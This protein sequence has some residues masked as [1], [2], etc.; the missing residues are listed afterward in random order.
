MIG[1]KPFSARHRYAG[2]KEITIREDAP[3]GLR[4]LVLDAARELGW[5]P[6]SLRSLVCRMLR[7][8]PDRGNWSEYPNIWDEVTYLIGRCEWFRVYD[9]IEA[10]YVAL[11]EHDELRGEDKAT[12][13]AEEINRA[14]IE[15]GIGWKLAD[16]QIVTRG[17]EAF[18]A[19]VAEAH[20]SLV[21]SARP[22]AASHIKDAL[23]CMSRR[24]K[25]NASGAVFHAMGS[26]ECIARDIV[27][28]PKATLGEILKRYP[29]LIPK[30]LDTAL[31]QIW[32]FAS[33]EA[34]HVQEGREISREDAE[35][36]VGLAAS[37]ATYVSR[38]SKP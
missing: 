36:V 35:L 26:L 30:P 38:N 10:L 13:Y 5:S 20:R 27:D 32:G 21:A 17:D 31:S 19:V 37:V 34:R 9:I 22:T 2:A 28:N 25:P 14:F 11:A 7:V 6:S 29:T 4:F 1:A 24:P 8:G 33:N 23:E 18:E 12:L 16:G 3:E 15:D